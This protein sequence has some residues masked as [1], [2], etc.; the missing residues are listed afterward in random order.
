MSLER[1]RHPEA[2]DVHITVGQDGITSILGRDVLNEALT[3]FHALEEH[4]VIVKSTGKPGLLGSD[5]HIIVIGN[6]AADMLLF[7][8]LF[9]Y[10][11]VFH[12]F[13]KFRFIEYKYRRIS[14]SFG[15][16]MR[17]SG[18]RKT[19]LRHKKND[20]MNNY[21]HSVILKSLI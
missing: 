16:V 3:A 11:D 18:I 6:G 10:L 19:Y 8:I 9:R 13:D 17:F 5:L 14:D 21:T 4:E 1:T 20:I 12:D 7:Q 2:V 15:Q